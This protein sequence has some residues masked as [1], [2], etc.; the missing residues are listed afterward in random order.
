MVLLACKVLSLSHQSG[1]EYTV[2]AETKEAVRLSYSIMYSTRAFP[3]IPYTARV[4]DL[5]GTETAELHRTL[6]AYVLYFFP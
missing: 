1:H 5:S 2:H 3:F 6:P 4:R